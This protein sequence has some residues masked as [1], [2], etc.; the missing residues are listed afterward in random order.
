MLPLFNFCIKV[1]A[2]IN[3]L[4]SI[5]VKVVKTYSCLFLDFK[6]N[7]SKGL[8]VAHSKGQSSRPAVPRIRSV[9]IYLKLFPFWNE[10]EYYNFIACIVILSTLLYNSYNWINNYFC[11]HSTSF[12][13]YAVREKMLTNFFS[14]DV[15]GQ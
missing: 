1:F 12:H 7:A 13:Y 14:S 11:S 6:W 2:Q 5:F 8:P 15:K 3:I 10:M 9:K 4:K